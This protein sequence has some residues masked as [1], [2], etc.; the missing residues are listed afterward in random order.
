[1]KC[2]IL[3][4]NTELVALYFAFP[5]CSDLV[6]AKV[7]RLEVLQRKRVAQVGMVKA[8]RSLLN[9]ANASHSHILESTF[10]ARDVQVNM[11]QKRK[12][13]MWK[14]FGFNKHFKAVQGGISKPS[15]RP[16]SLLFDSAKY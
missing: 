5:S 13:Y 10:A 15:F 6:G 7:T 1:M 3:L 9:V 11:L 2:D 14:K 16:M 4:A 8:F 12:V